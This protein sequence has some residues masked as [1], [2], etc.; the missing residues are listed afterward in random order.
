MQK[1]C[2]W[3]DDITDLRLALF[4]SINELYKQQIS[5]IPKI[6]I[7]DNI[8]QKAAMCHLRPN[9]KM[10]NRK[11][12]PLC[13]SNSQ[14]KKYEGKLYGILQ[15]KKDFEGMSLQGSWKPTLQELILKCK[16]IPVLIIQFYIHLFR[17]YIILVEITQSFFIL[18]S[19]WRNTR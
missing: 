15:R 5:T 13:I 19:R 11:I 17:S 10:K 7:K 12:C 1:I 18:Y 2:L 8:V 14:L 6:S 9:K 4:E 16:Y 3:F